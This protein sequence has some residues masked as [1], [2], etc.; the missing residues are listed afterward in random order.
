[1]ADAQTFA[2]DFVRRFVVGGKWADVQNDI[3][4]L[5]ARDVRGF[6]RDLVDDKVR[7]VVGRG[8]LRTD[9]KP[10]AT[11]GTGNECFLY[12]LRADRYEPVTG[13]HHVIRGQLLIWFRPDEG[14]WE[15][16]SYS[17]DATIDGKR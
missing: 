5:I 15:M 8:L 4:P 13:K 11:L 10:N 14:S 6:Q 3:S 17:Y 1:M 12:H 16:S 2:E 7:K 9:C